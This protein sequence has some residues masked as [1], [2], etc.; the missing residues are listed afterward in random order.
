M[1][2]KKKKS[3]FYLILCTPPHYGAEKKAA[4]LKMSGIKIHSNKTSFLFF[5]SNQRRGQC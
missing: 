4:L 5:I 2:K 1:F 3:V